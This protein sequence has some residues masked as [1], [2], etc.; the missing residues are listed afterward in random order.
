M[1]RGASAHA[2]TLQNSVERDD[3]VAA[4]PSLRRW[5]RFVELPAVPITTAPAACAKCSAA[6]PRP[7]E[8]SR[9]DPFERCS[10]N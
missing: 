3:A 9:M 1:L 2:R 8:P 10:L 5:H 6:K 7:P 4:T